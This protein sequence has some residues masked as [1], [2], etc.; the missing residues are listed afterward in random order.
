MAT[1]LRLLNVDRSKQVDGEWVRCLIDHR[2]YDC[3]P[4]KS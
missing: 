4:T 1:R 2:G 3:C